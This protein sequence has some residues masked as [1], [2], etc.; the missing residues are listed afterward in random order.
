MTGCDGFL[1]SRTFGCWVICLTLGVHDVT[2]GQFEKDGYYFIKTEGEEAEGYHLPLSLVR[3]LKVKHDGTADVEYQYGTCYDGQWKAW[4]LP[5]AGQKY[6]TDTDIP[7]ESVVLCD[8]RRGLG[9]NNKGKAQHR[10]PYK[11]HKETLRRLSEERS[12]MFGQFLEASLNLPQAATRRKSVAKTRLAGLEV[13]DA[14]N[15]EDHG[16]DSETDRESEE[17]AVES[18]DA[19][20]EANSEED[21]KDDSD[22]GESSTTVSTQGSSSVEEDGSSME[23]E[24]GRNRDITRP[25]RAKPGP[26]GPRPRQTQ[27]NQHLAQERQ[28]RLRKDHVT[29]MVYDEAYGP[30]ATQSDRIARVGNNAKSS[31]TGASSSG[32]TRSSKQKRDALVSAQ[33]ENA[34]GRVRKK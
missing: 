26:K 31:A 9:A 6:F 23:V 27:L 34:G 19:Q 18:G 30:A 29:R 4:L 22:E 20:G 15:A 28:R 33:Q 8:V 12:S 10:K 7:Y 17:E 32:Y 5:G 25:K 13:T 16:T 14:N 1:L 11:L 3:V 24:G 2:P 21:D